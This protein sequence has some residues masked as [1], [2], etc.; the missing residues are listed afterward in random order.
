[1]KR[2]G[3]TLLIGAILVSLLTWQALS[4][5][6]AYV[7][8]SPGV[9]YDTLGT[10]E[11]LDENDE[12]QEVELVT[13]DPSVSTDSKGELRLTTVAITREVELGRAIYYWFADDIAVVPR[14]LH[15]PD[16]KSDEEIDAEQTEMWTSSQA[17]ATTVALRELGYPVDVTVSSV[18]SDSPSAGELEDGD[19][20]V[21][22]DGEEVTSQQLLA[23]HVQE[24]PVDAELALKVRR[25]GEEVDATAR[26]IEAEDGVKGLSGVQV[27]P[28]QEDPYDFEI[29][30]EGLNVGGP[31]AGVVFALAMIDRVSEEDLT[32]G[33]VIAGTGTIDEEGVVGPIGGI[34][35]KVVGAHADGAEFFLTPEENCAAAAANAP[36]GLTL[37]K[38]SSVDDA[39]QGL[40]TL[41]DGG[42]P[43]TC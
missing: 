26:V 34:E 18:E 42:R 32:G 35:Q 38:I 39:L 2:R 36:D 37:V 33:E 24:L 12:V 28:V 20:V 10:Y 19:V 9:T 41:R 31:S 17:A 15:I 43:Q 16:G 8:L 7:A 11:Y 30:D 13:A 4:M 29:T 22:V 5:R 40:E 25:D 21:S 3:W 27:E 1:M 14:Q 23:D 6:V